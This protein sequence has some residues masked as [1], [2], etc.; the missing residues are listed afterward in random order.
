MSKITKK[1]Y[2]KLNGND[3]QFVKNFLL[4]Q[5]KTENK[6][7]VGKIDVGFVSLGLDFNNTNYINLAEYF[8]NKFV[9]SIKSKILFIESREVRELVFRLN[10][11]NQ[12]KKN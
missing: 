7:D 9:I 12:L 3:F 11:K 4:Y 10:I 6:A 2:R 1:I 8:S 5:D